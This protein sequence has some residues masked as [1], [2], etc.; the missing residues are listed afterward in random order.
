MNRKNYLLDMKRQ[1]KKQMMLRRKKDFN[2][3]KRG[4]R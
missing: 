4:K 2:R 3:F 1:Q